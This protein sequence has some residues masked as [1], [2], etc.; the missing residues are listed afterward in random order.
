MKKTILNLFA[1]GMIVAFS[2]SAMAQNTANSDATAS[3]TIIAPI[4]I[5]KTSDL[6]FGTV[7]NNSGTITLDTNGAVSSLDNALIGNDITTAAAA[8]GVIGEIGYTYAIILPETATLSDTG[9][10]TMIVNNFT[11]HSATNN[12]ALLAG[13]LNGTGTDI[14]T[15]G[16]DLIVGA[17]QVS[18]DYTGTF[19]VIVSYN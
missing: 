12:N 6:I 16:A 18:G 2:N 5:N 8:F 17:S 11:C 13:T 9:V 10:E 19:N 7:I 15:V 1:I 3:A 4:A 14:V